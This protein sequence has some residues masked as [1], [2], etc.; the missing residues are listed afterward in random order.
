MRYSDKPLVGLIKEC[1]TT[2]RVKKAPRLTDDGA[3]AERWTRILCSIESCPTGQQKYIGGMTVVRLDASPWCRICEKKKG[4][5]LEM[6]TGHNSTLYLAPHINRKH[7]GLSRAALS[8]SNP[9]TSCTFLISSDPYLGLPISITI[10][11]RSIDVTIS[12]I[13]SA[14]RFQK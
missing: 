13:S 5:F 12:Q 9:Y 1:E 11:T 14:I 6:C 2:L 7:R 4:E 3:I 8:F 10:S